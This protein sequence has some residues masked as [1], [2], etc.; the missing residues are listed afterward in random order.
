[1]TSVSGR[2]YTARPRRLDRNDVDKR[3]LARCGGGCRRF[4]PVWRRHEGMAPA[5]AGADRYRSAR[6]GSNSL[7]VAGGTCARPLFQHRGGCGRCEGGHEIV[8]LRRISTV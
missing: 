5:A 4:R 3:R 6:A 8:Y 2:A 7:P 1:M